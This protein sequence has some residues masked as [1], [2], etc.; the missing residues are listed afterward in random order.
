MVFSTYIFLFIFLPLVLVLYFNPFLRGRKFKNTLLLISSLLF[1]AWG[2]TYFVF[3][4]I[5]SIIMNYVL[6]RLIDS[7]SKRKFFP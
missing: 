7:G 2:E 5:L 3:I 4:M 1:Y 6:A